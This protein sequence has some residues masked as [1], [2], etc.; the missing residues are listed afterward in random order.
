[1]IGTLQLTDDLSFTTNYTYTDAEVIEGPLKGNDVE[2]TPE[3]AV[4]FSLF[5]RAPFGLTVNPRARYVGRTFQ[6]ITNEAIQDAHWVFDLFAAYRV[7]KHV[8]IFV[9]GTNIFDEQYVADGFSGS[10]GAP[11]QFS[12][13]LR[14]TF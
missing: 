12:G 10:L 13:G 8:E 11:R 9:T 7:H 2:G 1:M 6:D 14:V 5:Y 3:S 4:A